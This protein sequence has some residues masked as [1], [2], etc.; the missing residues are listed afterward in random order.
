MKNR[1]YWCS[2]DLEPD[3]VNCQGCGNPETCQ[4]CHIFHADAVR[5]CDERRRA[6][7][8]PL[9]ANDFDLLR[10]NF[11]KKELAEQQWNNE[12]EISLSERMKQEAISNYPPQSFKRG[13]TSENV[14]GGVVVCLLLGFPV[15][16]IG[17]L[18]QLFTMFIFDSLTLFFTSGPHP[19]VW[20]DSFH[21]SFFY[22]DYTSRY[23]YWTAF[24]I[25]AWSWIDY[26]PNEKIDDIVKCLRIIGT[27]VFLIVSLLNINL[28]VGSILGPLLIIFG[29]FIT[30]KRR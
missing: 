21:D 1:W 7:G 15:A 9:I 2:R 17:Q 12:R 28:F 18:F 29:L 30:A 25:A 27:G 3:Y 22:A 23:L 11:K 24:M 6:Q 14:L 8:L 26:H 16:Y 4:H 10:S 5:W 19:E 13:R 20:S